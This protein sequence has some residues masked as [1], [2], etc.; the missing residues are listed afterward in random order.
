MDTKIEPG[1]TASAA[2]ADYTAI[3]Q[4]VSEHNDAAATGQHYWGVALA[5]GTY[6][7][8]EA[9]T[10]PPP[11]T[12]EELAAQEEAAK[13][14]AE[15]EALPDTVKALQAAQADTDALAVDQ[16]YRVAMLELGL[17]DDTTTDTTT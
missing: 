8:Y 2:K 9:G 6:M 15:R 1:Y 5:D 14:Q 16:E 17:A 10:V 11:P 12:A 4:A 7:V 13:K 3:A